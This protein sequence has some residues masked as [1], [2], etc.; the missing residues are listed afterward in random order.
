MGFLLEHAKDI[1]DF[2]SLL[3]VTYIQKAML[4]FLRDFFPAYQT[5][6]KGIHR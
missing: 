3:I 4:A 5:Y 2:F 6:L 1:G